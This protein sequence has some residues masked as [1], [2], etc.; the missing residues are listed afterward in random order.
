MSEPTEIVLAPSGFALFKELFAPADREVV[1][2]LLAAPLVQIKPSSEPAA[3][4]AHEIRLA[5]F[6]GGR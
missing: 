3:R 2:V 4:V 1:R 6:G 5:R